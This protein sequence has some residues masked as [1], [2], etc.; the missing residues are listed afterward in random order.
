M[1]YAGRK[2]DGILRSRPQASHSGGLGQPIKAPLG[3]ITYLAARRATIDGGQIHS[4]R[5]DS[6]PLQVSYR[7]S[8]MAMVMAMIVDDRQHRGSACDYLRS[9]LAP[10]R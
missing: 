10:S 6:I 1:T 7:R 5:A 9:R 4:H 3:T 8:V 2:L